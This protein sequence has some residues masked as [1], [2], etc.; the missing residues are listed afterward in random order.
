MHCGERKTLR[1]RYRTRGTSLTLSRPLRDRF[2]VIA[3]VLTTVVM[4][5]SLPPPPFF[6]VISFF[7]SFFST[8]VAGPSGFNIDFTCNIGW[9][10]FG[11]NACEQ[12]RTTAGS[13]RHCEKISIS[14]YPS[15]CRYIYL[16]INLSIYLFIY[17]SIYLSII[18]KTCSFRPFL[19]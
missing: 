8:C 9:F 3:S 11:D 6:C 13:C 1:D 16:F 12:I 19:S 15:I 17:L 10:K 18:L 5:P 14:L 2:D 7:S 4:L